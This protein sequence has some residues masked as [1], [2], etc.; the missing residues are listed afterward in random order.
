M[1]IGQSRG[2]ELVVM[3]EEDGSV[4]VD[5]GS[6]FVPVDDDELEHLLDNLAADG[7][8]LRLLG[9]EAR[10]DDGD[11]PVRESD[12]GVGAASWVLAMAAQRGISVIREG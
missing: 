10:A 7:G 9:G 8:T 12:P 5:V 4:A 11:E 3:A 2:G 1:G 6:R